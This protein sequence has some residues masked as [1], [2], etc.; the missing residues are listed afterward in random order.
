MFRLGENPQQRSRAEKQVLFGLMRI[1][2]ARLLYYVY[3]F[4][5]KVFGREFARFCSNR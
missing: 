3:D 2:M 1:R 5:P 4:Q